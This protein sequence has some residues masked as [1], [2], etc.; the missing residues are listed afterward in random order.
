MCWEWGID[1]EKQSTYFDTK[2]HDAWYI[3]WVLVYSETQL[4]TFLLGFIYTWI[5][6][7]K[8]PLLTLITT[9]PHQVFHVPHSVGESGD[10]RLG[11]GPT[12]SLSNCANTGKPFSSS[13]LQLLCP[14]DSEQLQNPIHRVLW[15]PKSINKSKTPRTLLK[16]P[17]S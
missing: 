2:L 6:L 12:I 5:H 11:L 16:W 9:P 14:Q 1:K 13:V 17:I 4:P 15:T 3:W 10:N 7:S 8:V